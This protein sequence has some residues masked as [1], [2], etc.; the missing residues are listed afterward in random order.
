MIDFKPK[1]GELSEGPGLS[2]FLLL[3]LVLPLVSVGSI[4][5]S[6]NKCINNKS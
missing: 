1:P 4:S 2:A 6:G 5:G 3:A